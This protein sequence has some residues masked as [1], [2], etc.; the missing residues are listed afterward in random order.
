MSARR[1]SVRKKKFRF[2]SP[3]VLR[4]DAPFLGATVK[5][6]DDVFTRNFSKNLAEVRRLVLSGAHKRNAATATSFD[7]GSARLPRDELATETS[8]TPPVRFVDDKQISPLPT[9]VTLTTLK[10]LSCDQECD[11]AGAKKLR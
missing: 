9:F 5:E 3:T 11:D 6:W 4:G 7:L 1:S 10:E 8:Q 2:S